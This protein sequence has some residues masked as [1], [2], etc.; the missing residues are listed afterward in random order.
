MTIAGI[1]AEYNPFHNGHL[2]QL[3]EVRRRLQAEYIIVAMSGDYVQRGAPA[4]LPKHIRAEMALRAGADLIL[5]LPVRVST[6]SAEG[7]ALG[8]AEL[9]SSLGIITHLCFGCEDGCEGALQALGNWLAEEP[10]SF[11]HRLRELLKQGNSFPSARMKAVL[12]TFPAGSAVQTDGENITEEQL[13]SLLSRPN[14]LLGLEY[15]KALRRLDSDIKPVAIKR[16]GAQHHASACEESGQA[17]SAG[18]L[19]ETVFNCVSQENPCL[20]RQNH[21]DAMHFLKENMPSSSYEILCD[22]LAEGIWMNEK[23]LDL[24]LRL[25]LLS[26]NTESLLQIP[27]LPESLARRIL[28]LKNECSGFLPFVGLLK[29]KELTW[30]RIQRA[31]LH[32]VID[33]RGKDPEPDRFARVL[34]FRKESALLLSMTDRQ[35][36]LPLITR[37]RQ[38]GRYASGR[39][40]AYASN[41]YETILTS[42]A[43]SRKYRDEAQKQIVIV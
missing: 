2:Y 31:L 43:A 23:D 24:P 41:L 37:G 42:R 35:T 6:S 8:G 39:E 25:R 9:L 14:N 16:K 40:T 28:R 19:R 22:Q 12:D 11:R 17:A 32:V 15:I 33:L 3:N 20:S 21:P 27:D 1:I 7:F 5:E 30:S 18:M 38:S 10:P 36:E 26:E 34:G 4:L 13:I 29:T